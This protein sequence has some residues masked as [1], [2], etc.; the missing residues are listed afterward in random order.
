MLSFDLAGVAKLKFHG[1][2]KYVYEDDGSM[3]F[4]HP[5]PSKSEIVCAS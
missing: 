4:P 1:D 3:E 5:E 2:N